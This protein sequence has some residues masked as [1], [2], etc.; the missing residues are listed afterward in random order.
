MASNA[1]AALQGAAR[2]GTTCS[3]LYEAG[4]KIYDDAGFGE[5]AGSLFG[6]GIGLEVWERPFVSRHDDAREDVRLRRGMTICLE[7]MLAPV[8][9]GALQGLFVVEDMVAITDGDAD[10]LSDGVERGFLRISG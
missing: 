6:H 4:R 9:E 7:P 2:E 5:S 3:T 1:N 10:V 8:E